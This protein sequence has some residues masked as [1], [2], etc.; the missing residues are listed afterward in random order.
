[1]NKIRIKVRDK[2]L[3]PELTNQLII[4]NRIQKLVGNRRVLCATTLND[5]GNRLSF[6]D[7][8]FISH[9][10]V[11]GEKIS[12]AQNIEKIFHENIS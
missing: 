2:Y 10:R 5:K 11:R 9:H 6:T 8:Q 3:I 1:M 12:S 7:D 4:Y